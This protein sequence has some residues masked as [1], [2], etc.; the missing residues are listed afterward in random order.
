M[1]SRQRSYCLYIG[2]RQCVEHLL[3]GFASDRM[4]PERRDVQQ[5]D[6]NEGAIGNPRMG[7]NQFIGRPRNLIF[8]SEPGPLTI[9][10]VIRENP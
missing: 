4:A 1:R 2:L 10:F 7:K 6:Q 3:S 5:R 8:R 9:D